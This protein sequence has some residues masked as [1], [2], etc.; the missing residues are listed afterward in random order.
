L[1]W[2]K[3][4]KIAD[5]FGEEEG[6]ALLRQIEHAILEIQK[7]DELN[8]GVLPEALV[9]EIDDAEHNIDELRI[10]VE[11]LLRNEG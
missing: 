6:E 5:E 11:D 10:Y 4:I 1:S 2:E 3:L 9:K 7:F 8:E